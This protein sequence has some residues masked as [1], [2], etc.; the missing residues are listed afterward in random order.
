MMNVTE[1]RNL[2]KG[3]LVFVD[4]ESLG[5]SCYQIMQLAVEAFAVSDNDEVLAISRE[6]IDLVSR[7]I[8]KETFETEGA[9]L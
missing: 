8:L 1:L 9:A 5:N 6:I 4:S 7:G 2:K 3:S